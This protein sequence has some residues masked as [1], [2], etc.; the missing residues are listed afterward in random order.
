WPSTPSPARPSRRT[1][2]A[3]F[4]SWRG[5]LGLPGRFL[6]Q[7][8]KLRA[9][10]VV[11][12]RAEVAHQLRLAVLGQHILQLLFAQRDEG[13]LKARPG[14]AAVEADGTFLQHGD[15]QPVRGQAN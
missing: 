14:A 5:L 9:V 3:R 13:P 6:D 1:G 10:E 2:R 15:V 12:G 4:R 8:L 11:L 7:R